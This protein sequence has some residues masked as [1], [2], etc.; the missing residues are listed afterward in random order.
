MLMS[1]ARL[2]SVLRVEEGSELIVPNQAIVL[3]YQTTT[4][5]NRNEPTTRVVVLWTTSLCP[6]PEHSSSSYSI[7]QWDE[8]N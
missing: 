7:K 3:Q 4:Y 1:S 5:H 8:G 2:T 6:C